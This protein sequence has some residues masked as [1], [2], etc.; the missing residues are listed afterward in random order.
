MEFLNSPLLVH[1]LKPFISPAFS[2]L[3]NASH[4]DKPGTWKSSLTPLFPL[5][6][7]T[8][9]LSLKSLP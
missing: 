3:V 1:S 4:L 6:L 5:L 7:S 9:N 2:V 8:S